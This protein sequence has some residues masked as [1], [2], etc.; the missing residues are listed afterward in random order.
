M[1]FR[2]KIWT[3]SF[4]PEGGKKGEV[5]K[6]SGTGQLGEKKK[7]QDVEKL[8]HRGEGRIERKAPVKKRSAAERGEGRERDRRAERSQKE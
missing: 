8:N 6:K 3:G 1:N 4:G 7:S 2:R 5:K